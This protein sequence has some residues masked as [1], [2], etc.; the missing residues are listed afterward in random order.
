[1]GPKASGVTRAAID[2][3]RAQQS[4]ICAFDRPG[5]NVQGM[6]TNSDRQDTVPRADVYPG[7]A[8]GFM[9][10]DCHAPVAIDA[11]Q[12]PNCGALFKAGLADRRQA[13]SLAKKWL[14]DNPFN[15]REE[16]SADAKHIGKRI[17]RVVNH[18]WIIA[19]L[20]PIVIG[21]LLSVLSFL[22]STVR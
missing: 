9:C 12:C 11:P 15:P 5:A 4:P 6:E 13:A 8:T 10:P 22:N 16:I 3:A 14:E 21:I 17:D 7:G 2:A 1:M 19:V 18:M 20:L